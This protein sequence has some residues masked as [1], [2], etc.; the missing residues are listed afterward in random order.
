LREIVDRVLIALIDGEL[1]EALRLGE[2][3]GDTLAPLIH[4][5]EEFLSLGVATCWSSRS[6]SA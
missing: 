5:A 1:V 4:E 3:V 6:A 2:V